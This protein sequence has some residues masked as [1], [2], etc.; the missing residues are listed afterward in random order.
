MENVQVDEA[1]SVL[2]KL[3]FLLSA[4]AI[5][6]GRQEGDRWFMILRLE[7][8]DSVPTLVTVENIPENHLDRLTLEEA[9][10]IAQ[11]FAPEA[12]LDFKWAGRKEPTLY[13]D[14]EHWENDRQV[15]WQR[16][17]DMLGVNNESLSLMFN[18]PVD[19]HN[20]TA[21]QMGELLLRY[22]GV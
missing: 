18:Q 4:E 12:F 7:N 5:L 17:L 20:L 16:V 1:Q 22:M 19:G 6:M 8:A 10:E 14:L 13:F 3:K 21:P 15:R 2:N 9:E 11:E